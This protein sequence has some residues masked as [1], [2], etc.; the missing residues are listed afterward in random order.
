MFFTFKKEKKKIQK[1]QLVPE[2]HFHLAGRLPESLAV[3]LILKGKTV[4]KIVEYFLPASRT[5][6][7]KKIFLANLQ[8]TF[9]SCTVP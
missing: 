4:Q 7:L 3:T 8:T 9:S 5:V 6:F 2:L 1:S